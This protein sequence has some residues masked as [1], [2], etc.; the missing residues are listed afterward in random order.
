[1]NPSASETAGTQNHRATR[2]GFLHLSD[3]EWQAVERMATSIGEAAVGAMLLSLSRDEQHASI[4]QFIQH[5]LDEAR[6]HLAVV[7]QQGSQQADLLRQQ[8]AQQLDLLRQQ[9]QMA[10]AAATRT[11]RVEPLKIEVSKYKAVESDNVLRWFV[12]LDDAIAARRITDEHMRVTFALSN[13]G[14]RAK[15]WALGLKLHDPHCFGSLQEFKAKLRRTFEP[16]R[17]EF[18]A[19]AE[20]LD[21]KQGKRDIH[22]Y[23]QHARFLADSIVQDP[24]DEQTQITA[25]IKGLNDGPIKTHLFRVELSTLDEAIAIAQQ[26]DFSLQQAFVHSAAYRPPRRQD[27]GGAEAM[28]LSYVESDQRSRGNKGSQKCNR[29]QKNGHYAY[30]C[31]APRPVPHSAAREDRPVG[32]KGQG[33]RSYVATKSQRDEQP[34]NGR[35]Q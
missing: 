13:L 10:A 20:Y 18:R 26:E 2:D 28:D 11:P 32:K 21:L 17:A 5:E 9:Q 29:C 34:K 14:G 6:S 22:A 23:V 12:E 3:L 24:I 1:M 15:S 27:A 19:R 30:E 35:G 31:N 16:P 33:K 7:Q 8:G 25:F 4:A